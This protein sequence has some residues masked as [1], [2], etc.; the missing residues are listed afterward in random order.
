MALWVVALGCWG[1]TLEAA[2]QGVDD[3][4][5]ERVAGVVSGGV[6]ATRLAG[7][8]G[9]LWGVGAGVWLGP[10]YLGGHGAAVPGMLALDLAGNE[11]SRLGFGYAGLEV[12]ARAWQSARFEAF[13]GVLAGAGRAQLE[14]PVVRRELGADNF[15]A[16]EPSFRLGRVFGDGA[17]S[18]GL[19][20]RYRQV[21]G[22]EDLPGLDAA[23]LRGPTLMLTV[24]L[25]RR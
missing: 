21:W 7:R 16:L 15:L 11:G 25:E 13:V 9:G 18:A 12:A 20:I 17:I 8:F 22:V 3:V 4:E 14:E 2:A 10:L 6:G 1:S 19:A 5:E 23:D 24:S